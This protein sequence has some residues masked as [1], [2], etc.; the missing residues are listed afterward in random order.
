MTHPLEQDKALDFGRR[1]AD[2]VFTDGVRR[3]GTPRPVYLQMNEADLITVLAGAFQLGR[4]YQRAVTA[5]A[6]PADKAKP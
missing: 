6:T 1:L 4:D 5:A 3:N 2:K